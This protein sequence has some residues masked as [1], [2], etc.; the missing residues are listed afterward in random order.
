MSPV[1][2]MLL[3]LLQLSERRWGDRLH[4]ADE[5]RRSLVLLCRLDSEPDILRALA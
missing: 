3:L 1:L 4:C 2:L 5:L